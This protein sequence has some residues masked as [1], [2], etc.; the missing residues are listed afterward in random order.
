MTLK[1]LAERLGASIK[2]IEFEFDG[3]CKNCKKTGGTVEPDC[4]KC[5]AVAVVRVQERI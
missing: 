2:D 1:Q 5:M 3:A 4:E